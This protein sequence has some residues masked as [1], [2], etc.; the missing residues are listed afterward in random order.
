[1]S[2]LVSDSMII[3]TGIEYVQWLS[4]QLSCLIHTL[5]PTPARE[6]LITLSRNDNAVDCLLHS[7]TLMF[8]SQIEFHIYCSCE[9]VLD[10]CSC[11]TPTFVTTFSS[12]LVSI[13]WLVKMLLFSAVLLCFFVSDVFAKQNPRFG[14][15]EVPI[16]SINHLLGGTC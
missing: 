11:S 3:L 9:I 1:M 6:G 10:V 13:V 4:A 7:Q 15:F 16:Y 5:F 12:G 8:R 14:K 2:R